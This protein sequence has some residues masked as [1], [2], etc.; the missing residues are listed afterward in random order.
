[1]SDTRPKLKFR[2]KLRCHYVTERLPLRQWGIVLDPGSQMLSF[3]FG[4]KM[5]FFSWWSEIVQ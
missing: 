1:M 5:V 4:R 3:H 2:R